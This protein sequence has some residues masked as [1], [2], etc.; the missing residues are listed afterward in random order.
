M[1]L[2]EQEIRDLATMQ[3]NISTL[4]A[5]VS[6]I[7]EYISKGNERHQ[8]VMTSLAL[9]NE[10]KKNSEDYQEECDLQRRDHEKRL[11][12]VEGFQGRQLKYATVAG[13]GVAFVVT[14]WDKLWNYLKS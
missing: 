1:P 9:L 14:H 8:E 3:A 6:K 5:T 4:N 10:S 12:A 11:T 13:A 7:W 2:T